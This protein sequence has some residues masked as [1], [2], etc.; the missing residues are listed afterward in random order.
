MVNIY[1]NVLTYEPS[2][3]IEINT[4][5][6]F[7]LSAGHERQRPCLSGVEGGATGHSNRSTISHCEC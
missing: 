5:R 6:P 2:S 4:G 3:R 7:A 1:D